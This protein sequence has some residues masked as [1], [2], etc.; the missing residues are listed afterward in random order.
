[1]DTQQSAWGCKMY[2]QVVDALPAAYRR[3]QKG[4]GDGLLGARHAGV[5]AA[6]VSIE[7]K[8]VQV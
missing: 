7:C 4:Q 5:L 6:A 3:G 8:L 1:M 2:V